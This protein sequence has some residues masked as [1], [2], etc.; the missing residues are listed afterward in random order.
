[1]APAQGLHGNADLAGG[2]IVPEGR[3][4]LQ[5]PDVDFRNGVQEHVPENAGETEE[6]LILHPAGVGVLKHLGRQL[7]LP[8]DQVVRQLELRR[9]E[10][11]LAVA[12]VMAVAPHRQAALRTLEGD[13]DPLPRQTLRQGEVPDVTSHR[14]EPLRDLPGLHILQA[15]PGVLGVHVLGAA[16]A[17]HLHMGRHG[18][19]VPAPAVRVRGE[20]AGDGPLIIFRV[21]EE[22]VPVEG[23][24]GGPLREDIA[25]VGVGRFPAVLEKFRGFGQRIVEFLHTASK[26]INFPKKS[27]FML[28]SSSP[29]YIQPAPERISPVSLER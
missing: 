4:D 11:V 24:P 14:V 13:E 22:P 12:R 20:E 26:T 1:M 6:V 19:D 27:P 16:V 15:V 8:G 2:E 23:K 29:P 10:A 7:V 3:G 5:I 25:V 21:V 17:L 9:G 28:G 18:D